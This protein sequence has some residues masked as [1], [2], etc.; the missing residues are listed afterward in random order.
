MQQNNHF[1][2]QFVPC[3]VGNG[4]QAAAWSLPVLMRLAL[5]STCGGTTICTEYILVNYQHLTLYNQAPCWSF[6]ATSDIKDQLCCCQES[7]LTN[8]HSHIL[9][10][11]PFFFSG[12]TVRQ[13]R[14]PG[15][16]PAW[17][18][19]VQK[20]SLLPLLKLLCL[21]NKT[22]RHRNETCPSIVAYNQHQRHVSSLFIRTIK[23]IMFKKIGQKKLQ[24]LIT[25]HHLL[26]SIWL[27]ETNNQTT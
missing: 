23:H 16:E 21:S 17:W 14:C 25:T 22:N 8:A 10:K 24:L 4:T 13:A 27:S 19:T 6:S 20:M 5:F 18:I 1:S 12:I 3:A 26:Y 2:K 15:T 9:L 11:Q 7:Q